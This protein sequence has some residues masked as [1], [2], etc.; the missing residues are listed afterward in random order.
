MTEEQ[1]VPPYEPPPPPPSPPERVPFW[2][3]S[4]LFLFIGM[5][6]PSMVAGVF[7]VKGVLLAFH[8]HPSIRAVELLPAQFLGYLILFLILLAIFRLQYGRPFWRSL[9]WVDSHMPVLQLVIYGML[10]AFAVALASTFL[11][12]PETDTPMKELLSDRTSMILIGIFGVT[13]GPLCEELAFRGFLQPLLVRS[14]GVVPGIVGAAIPFGLLHLQE[15]GYSW[16]HALLIAAAGAAFGWVRHRTGSTRAS[17]I[18]HAA[19]NA[20]FFLALFAQKGDLP[21]T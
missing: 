20:L 7:L 12:M 3:Y 9:G 15:Y 11:K 5:A 4:D 14:L 1:P 16:R 18:M 21:H 19:Y 17:T 13:V 10:A 2:G 6:I 8:L